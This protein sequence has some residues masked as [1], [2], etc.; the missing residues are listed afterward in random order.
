MALTDVRLVAGGLD[1]PEGPVALSDGSILVVEMRRGTLTRIGADGTVV[2]VVTC[3]GGPNGLAVGPDGAVY[4]C[5][6]G[7]YETAYQGGRILRV[8]L[9]TEAIDVVYEACDGEALSGPNDLVFES[10]GHFWFTDNG[11]FHAHGRDYGRIYYAAPD[12]SSITKVID[13]VDAPNGIGLSPDQ[14]TLYFAETLTG[15]LYRRAIVGPG[16]LEHDRVHDPETLVCGLGGVQ[17]FDSLAVDAAGHVSV[18]TLIS[19]CITVASPDG[20]SVTQYTLPEPYADPMPTNLCFAGEGLETAF[21][22]LSETGRL[23]A[24][25][26]PEGGGLPLAFER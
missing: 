23:V 17:M 14:Q 4:V 10:S 3:G 13:R 20:S 6:N 9:D 22:T 24:A 11:K 12:G 15:R 26:W 5:D 2:Q 19:G 7:G 25:P 18:G 1:F 8:D 16:R 21:I